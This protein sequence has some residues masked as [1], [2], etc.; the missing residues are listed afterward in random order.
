MS[1]ASKQRQPPRRVRLDAR[2][3]PLAV[4][5]A[6]LSEDEWTAWLKGRVEGHDPL[7]GQEMES[8]DDPLE[9][10]RAALQQHATDSIEERHARGLLRAIDAVHR[11]AVAAK[12][13]STSSLAERREELKDLVA[14]GSATLRRKLGRIPGVAGHERRLLEL[15]R[16]DLD[17]QVP[18]GPRS[19]RVLALQLL[20]VLGM[21]AD[22]DA[23]W[24]DLLDAE[25][26]LVALAFGALLER[27]AAGLPAHLAKAVEVLCRHS[28]ELE[29]AALLLDLAERRGEESYTQLIREAA[30]RLSRTHLGRIDAIA[31][32]HGLPPSR[33]QPDVA[34]PR[35]DASVMGD[36]LSEA[37]DV[38]LPPA[39]PSRNGRPS[40]NASP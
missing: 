8:L 34:R 31:R 3:L 37:L 14:H 9:P 6:R 21:P 22:D 40:F 32:E 4:E 26:A 11:E 35:P 15:A 28:R 13:T 23:F 7:T 12:K 17:G 5:V 33:F 19:L 24:A 16:S 29:L 30:R 27:G 25:D 39:R 2:G 1:G 36:R 38:E 18:A 10:I 20:N